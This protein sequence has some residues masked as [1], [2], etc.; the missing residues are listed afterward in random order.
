MFDDL[1]IAKFRVNVYCL[2]IIDKKNLWTKT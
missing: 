2:N 1:V